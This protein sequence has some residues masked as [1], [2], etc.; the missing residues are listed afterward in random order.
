MPELAEVKLMGDYI[1]LHKDKVFK[2]ISKS[3]ASKIATNLNISYNKFRVSAKTRGKELLLFL[4]PVDPVENTV[5]KLRVT[6]GM[7]GNWLYYNPADPSVEKESKHV[8]LYMEEESGMRLGLTDV[9]RFAKW[10][11]NDFNE[12]RGPCPL[13]DYENFHKNVME[14]YRKK[15]AFKKPVNEV[16]MNQE[17]FNGIG[18][19]LR[20]EILYRLDINPFSKA[21]DL[22][23]EEMKSLLQM[24]HQCVS[25]AYVL[26]GGQ[27]K[28]WKNPIETDSTSFKEWMKCYG[29][30]D[31]KTDKNGRTFW[32]D[33]KR[34]PLR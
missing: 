14:N 9:R 30:L 25:D 4:H 13:T 29:K 26:G 28:D 22:G 33:A 19:Y 3:D 23:E 34:W 32:Y 24:C 2:R 11:W 15:S 7:S 31:Q 1:N 8:H 17:W 20:A 21:S 10:S 27:L 18:N 5:Y 12:E 16:L 6:L